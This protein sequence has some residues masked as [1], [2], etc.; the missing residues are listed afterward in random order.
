M[1]VDRNR[2]RSLVRAELEKHLG[3]SPPAPKVRAAAAFL[4][5]YPGPECNE[6]LDFPTRKRCVIEPHRFC[7]NSGYCKKLG[8]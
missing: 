3:S 4:E 8:Y 5:I 6:D 1:S 7:I 2:V